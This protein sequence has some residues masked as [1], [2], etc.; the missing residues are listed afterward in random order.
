MQKVPFE[1]HIL[2]EKDFPL[3]IC[4]PPSPLPAPPPYSIEIVF[5][6]GGGGGGEGHFPHSYMLTIKKEHIFNHFK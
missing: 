6:Y 1:G 4:L 5:F 3:W 2:E